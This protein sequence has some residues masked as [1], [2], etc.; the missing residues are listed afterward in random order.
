[1]SVFFALVG[2]TL[3]AVGAAAVCASAALNAVPRK[4]R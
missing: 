2:G 3:F 4:Q 1:M